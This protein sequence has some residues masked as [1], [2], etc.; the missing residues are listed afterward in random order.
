LSYKKNTKISLYIH[1]PFCAKKCYYCDFISFQQHD[2]FKKLY[3]D[4][5]VSEII[6]FATKNTLKYKISTIFIGGGTPSLYPNKLLQNLFDILN[7]YFD[8]LL[9]TE[10][11]IEANPSD[12]TYE[13]LACWKNVGINRIS[14]GVQILNDDVLLRL[15]R[16]QTTQEAINT[17]EII[18]KNFENFSVDLMV[19]LPGSTQEI[20]NET[21]EKILSWK[22]KHI[23]VYFLTLYEKTK[24]FYQ[25]KNKEV[26]LPREEDIVA[27]YGNAVDILQKHNFL[28]YEISNFAKK[29]FESIH[30]QSYWNRSAYRGFGLGASSFDGFCRYINE[31][32]IVMYISKLLQGDFKDIS[33]VE[34]LSFEQVKIENIML[35]LRQTKGISLHRMLYFY[36]ES[37]RED[38][39]KKLS[40]LK[41]YSYLTVNDDIIRLSRKGMMF[42]NFVILKLI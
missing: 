14:L 11:S 9:T 28:Q 19:G 34:K 39:I 30:N 2:S 8:L 42:E 17:A 16:K 36:Q 29:N 5:L 33:R 22:L 7:R 38:L 21:L 20:W 41:K 3:H 24:L 18:A 6:D 13:K 37:E 40:F 1:W 32:N 12:I 10:I 31:N 23:S 4:A 15:N 26:L 25:V 35:S 27:M